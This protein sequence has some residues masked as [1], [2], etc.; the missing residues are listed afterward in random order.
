MATATCHPLLALHQSSASIEVALKHELDGVFDGCRC[1]QTRNHIADGQ[2]L[3]GHASEQPP[4]VAMRSGAVAE[5]VHHVG[6]T[7][8]SAQ[9]A[10]PR[11]RAERK[12][13]LEPQLHPGPHRC[14]R[15]R[16]LQHSG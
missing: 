11:L 16:M 1:P 13:A 9:G 3:P 8:G 2:V 7:S 5:K 14:I 4:Y 12:M 10:A 6:R 15:L